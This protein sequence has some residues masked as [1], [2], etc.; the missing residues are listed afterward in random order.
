MSKMKTAT[1]FFPLLFGLAAHGAAEPATAALSQSTGRLVSI[2]AASALTTSAR[3]FSED[4]YVIKAMKVDSTTMKLPV[5]LHETPR[6]LSVVEQEQIKDLNFHQLA[7]TFAYIPGM[8]QVGETSESYHFYS[9]GFHM[10]PDDTRVDGFQGIAVEDGPSPTLFGIDRVV[11]L[12]G[13][14]GL[15]YGNSSLPGGMINLISKQPQDTLHVDIDERYSTYDGGGVG[16]G[17]RDSVAADLDLTGPLTED[18]RLLYRLLYSTENMDSFVNDGLSRNQYT[19]LSLTYKIDGD[20]SITPIFQM[21]HQWN[22]ALSPRISPGTTPLI[23]AN[24]SGS[25]DTSSLNPLSVNLDAGGRED[26]QSM[27]G[28]DYRSRLD[29]GVLVNGGYRYR[30]YQYQFDELKPAYNTLMQ[31]DPSDPTSWTV[32]R[33]E[34]ASAAET[35]NHDFDINANYEMK[36]SDWLKNLTQLGINGRYNGWASNASSPTQLTQSAIN[37]YSGQTAS[38]AVLTHPALTVTQPLNK[39]LYYNVYLQDQLSLDH[40]LWVLDLGLG[41]ADQT[42]AYDSSLASKYTPVGH[43]QGQ[44]IPDLGLV[45]NPLSALAI[46]ASY[47]ES[48]SPVTGS[49]YQDANGQLGNFAPQTGQN[50]EAGF[51]LDNDDDSASLATSVYWIEQD[52]VL[53]ES[54]PNDLVNGQPYYLQTNGKGIV[55]RGF[56]MS[57]ELQALTD[58]TIGA[59]AAY[60]LA[61][62]QGGSAGSGSS[63]TTVIANSP[64]PGTPDWA[65]DIFSR[66]KVSQGV[67]KSL[68]ASLGLVWEGQRLSS[69]QTQLAPD[70]LWLPAY[71]RVDLGF[72]YDLSMRLKLA[73]SIQNALDQLIFVQGKVGDALD[74]DA[75]RTFTLRT[76]Y[77]F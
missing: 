63:L 62:N 4:T 58:W 19:Q 30:D 27:A 20:S 53:L 7:D 29:N 60:T 16:F 33:Q 32:S 54:G 55:S 52:N 74:I 66:Y 57:G 26:D 5:S 34:S 69:T 15:L 61:Q 39:D 36:P 41:Y 6:S 8:F 77:E 38:N 51:K 28:F 59:G 68:G 46:Y 42:F 47:S 56:E 48:Y 23:N 37:I 67:F 73:L 45:F 25:I 35:W 18:H 1:C 11:Y 13:P 70:P 71:T 75:P 24:V 65:F 17:D 21:M 3:A 31:G 2:S 49:N 9:R 76:D 22:P 14:S 10:A 40:G 64:A 12:R 44:W 50:Y 43:P 72:S